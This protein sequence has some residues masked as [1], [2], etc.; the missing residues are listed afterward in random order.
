MAFRDNPRQRLARRIEQDV[1]MEEIIVGIGGYPEFRKKRHRR[2]QIG[3]ARCQSDGAF[4][5]KVR[6]GHTHMRNAD[7]R[8]RK[9]V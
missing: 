6:I 5:I 3:S 1:L 4:G 8:P 2:G 7:C 9:A